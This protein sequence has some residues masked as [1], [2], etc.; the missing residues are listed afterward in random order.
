MEVKRERTSPT[1]RFS[2]QASGRRS[3]WWNSR[4]PIW[5]CRKFCTTRM[6]CERRAVVA[7]V[8]RVEQPE[9]QR[10]HHEQVRVAARDHLVHGDL[11]VERGGDHQ[12]LED[13]REHEDLDQRVGEAAQP[14][15]EGGE[16][17]PGPL[18]L[19]REALGRRDLQRDAG[20]VLRCL[21]DRVALLAGG[22]VVHHDAPAG[23]RLQ[24]HEVVQV[25]VQ[26]RRQAQLPRGGRA[27]SAA[28]GRPGP[29]GS[30]PGSARAA[31]PP[32]ATP[33]A[34]AE[35]CSGR[36]GGRDRR[37][38]WPGRRGRTRPPRSA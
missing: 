24:D 19:R 26:D 20:Q 28:A 27:R 8:I 17:Q 29:A 33:D 1:W 30:P 10:K 16:G 15:P 11:H 3:R 14:A 25:P 5:K 35:A 38:P 4:A 18:V 22:G 12:H 13:G 32:S 6:T 31:S 34:G 36:S 2:N 9:A 7:T 21:G 37:R 23:D